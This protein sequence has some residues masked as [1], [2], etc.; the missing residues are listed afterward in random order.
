MSEIVTPKFK[1]FRLQGAH[2]ASLICITQWVSSHFLF[3]IWTL[4]RCAE[5]CCDSLVLVL[6]GS[7]SNHQP[8]TLGIDENATCLVPQSE[9]LGT[10]NLFG[11][12][13]ALVRPNSFN[14]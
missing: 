4:P 2:H 11:A 14:I 7:N 1:S 5:T 10:I 13:I 3:R 12:Y 6:N 8:E 9:G